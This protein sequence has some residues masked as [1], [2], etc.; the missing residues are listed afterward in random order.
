GDEENSHDSAPT[1]YKLDAADQKTSLKLIVNALGL[2]PLRSKVNGGPGGVAS[3]AYAATQ[4][5]T[6]PAATDTA[7]MQ[8]LRRIA[9]ASILART[10]IP[11]TRVLY[12]FHIRVSW[13]RYWNNSGRFIAVAASIQVAM[14]AV[15]EIS[16]RPRL[17]RLR[18]GEPY[19][20]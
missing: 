14:E 6:A 5:L 12:R 16:R 20:F 1:R 15:L 4:R 7:T 10:S 17:V 9:V 19:D 8:P 11:A 3:A 2:R 13:P 18:A